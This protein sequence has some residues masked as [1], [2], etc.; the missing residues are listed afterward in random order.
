MNPGGTAGTFAIAIGHVIQTSSS[1]KFI[2]ASVR[3]HF[4][5][6][7]DTGVDDSILMTQGV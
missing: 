6:N 7:R 3:F 4:D 1:T 5:P 2:V